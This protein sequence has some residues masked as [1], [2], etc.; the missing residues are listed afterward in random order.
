MTGNA[1]RRTRTIWALLVGVVDVVVR[2]GRYLLIVSAEIDD[3]TARGETFYDFNV[4][5]R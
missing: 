3:G 4:V 2:A 5:V 1:A